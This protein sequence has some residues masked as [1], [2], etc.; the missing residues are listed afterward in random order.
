MKYLKI[1]SIALFVLLAGC[2][3][4][5]KAANAA[6]AT[7]S[8]ARVVK[9]H[10]AAKTDFTTMKSRLSVRYDNDQ[11]ARSFTVNLRMEK[12]KQ[13]WM[14]ASILGFTGAKAYITP[15][16]VQFYDKINKRAFDG[17]FSLISDFLGEV[18]TFEQLQDLLL[19]QAVEPLKNKDFS[20]VNNQYQF[21]QQQ[22]I[23]KMFSLRPTDFKIAEQSIS[24]PSE[25][26]LLKVNYPAYQVVEDRIVP[27]VININATQT[28]RVVKVN[29]EF[30]SVEFNREMTFPFDMPA[31]YSEFKL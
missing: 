5:Q 12:G 30:K 24:K 29:M 15:D 2:S 23:T 26:K 7:A 19:G 17:D 3:S 10:Q 27:T 4:K 18:V 28:N 13:I 9:A 20:I 16:R 14:S 21:M 1:I 11:E 25:N 22:L 6:M 8:K 31:G